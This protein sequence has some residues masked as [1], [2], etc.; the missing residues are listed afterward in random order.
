MTLSHN[1]RKSPG[2]VIFNTLETKFEFNSSHFLKHI[3][4]LCLLAHHVARGQDMLHRPILRSQPVASYL[5]NK[6]TIRDYWLF[7]LAHILIYV[8]V[9]NRR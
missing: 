2:L 1:L 3:I 5:F 8:D 9:A 4:T 6:I 7:A